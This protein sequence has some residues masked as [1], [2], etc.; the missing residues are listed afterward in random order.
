MRTWAS[1]AR[2]REGARVT[3][4]DRSPRR[5]ARTIARPASTKEAS[6][7]TNQ[8]EARLFD[9]LPSPSYGAS[10]KNSAF[11]LLTVLLSGCYTTKVYTPAPAYGPEHSDRQWFTLAGLVPLS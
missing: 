5:D 1:T 3:E 4:R 11:V 8:H 6:G 7:V 9:A 2:T 10:M